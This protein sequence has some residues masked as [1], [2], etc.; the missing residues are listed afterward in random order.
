MPGGL[1]VYLTGGQ[2]VYPKNDPKMC[3]LN[4]SNYRENYAL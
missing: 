4:H 2:Q 1:K 3:R